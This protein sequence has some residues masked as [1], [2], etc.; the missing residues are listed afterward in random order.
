MSHCL[1]DI[2]AKLSVTIE[3]PDDIKEAISKNYI[4]APECANGAVEIT[5]DKSI[6]LG[7]ILKKITF[8]TVNKR[9]ESTTVPI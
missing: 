7:I 5:V 1:L 8:K 2:L 4:V 3:L 9:I 6:F